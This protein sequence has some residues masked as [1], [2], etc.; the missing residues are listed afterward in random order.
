M[1]YLHALLCFICAL[2]AFPFSNALHITPTNASTFLLGEYDFIIV[3]GGTAGLTVANRLSEDSSVTVLV[4]EAGQL[5]N[6]RNISSP[7]GLMPVPGMIGS[8]FGGWLRYQWNLTTTP[9]TYLDNQ[10]IAFS[11]GRAIGGSSIL[12]GLC[13]T[14]GATSDFDAWE[15]LGN[16]GWAW[17]DMLP[18]FKK[19]SS[20]PLFAASDSN[21]EQSEHFT[22]NTRSQDAQDLHIHPD[23]STHGTNGSVHVSYPRYFYDQS[24]N[25][26]RGFA[27]L[28]LPIIGEPNN[29]RAAGAMIVPS[30]M[31]ANDQT[32]FDARQ[33]HFNPSV[34]RTNL[35][36]ATDQRVTRLVLATRDGF[37]TR[38]RIVG[39]EFAEHEN[40]TRR[41]I[42]CLREVILSAGAIFSPTLLQ[43]SGIGPAKVLQHLGIPIEIDLP[44]VGYNLQDHPVVHVTYYYSN[45]SLFRS[46]D[47]HGDVY[48]RVAQTYRHNRTGPWTAPL[49]NTVAFP[50]LRWVTHAWRK[51]AYRIDAADTELPN[52]TPASVRKG[53]ERQKLLLREQILR[54]DTGVFEVMATSWGELTIAAQKT[55]SRGTVRP[56]TPSMFDPPLLD[57]RYCSNPIDCEILVLGL[58][59]NTKLIQ[60]DAMK[61]L[62]PIPDKG[63]NTTDADE[64]MRRVLG[65]IDT[66]RHPCGTTAMLPLDLGGVVDSELKVYGTCNLRVVDAGI[67][68][69]I[70]AAHLQASVYA[71]AEKVGAV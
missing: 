60:T 10:T 48:D 61:E 65:R 67:M 5:D 17:R 45:S 43:V 25:I 58:Q 57:P 42:T 9:Q 44:G 6:S 22:P 13:W 54:N 30:S 2:C 23:M 1:I 20:H 55:F 50:A 33:A 68:P 16:R 41:T 32:R 66:E 56:S 52:D 69:L 64:L 29:G 38:R 15:R 62:M 34:H 21:I 51:I 36:I 31:D 12:N 26:L 71:I 63:F 24:S 53:Y 8:G 37:T 18:Y 40:S 39:V 4:L 27:E 70:P 59:L 47:I 35:H 46:T 28:G 14:R 7:S 49:V 3:G 19:A 11:Q